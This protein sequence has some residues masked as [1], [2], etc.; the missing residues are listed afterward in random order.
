[1]A[2]KALNFADI[3][4]KKMADIERPP[5]LPVGTYSWSVIKIP[6]IVTTAD[7]AWDIVEFQVRA[8]GHEDDVDPAD[9]PGEIVGVQQRLAFMFD[10]NDEVKFMQTEFRLRM[11]LETHLKVSGPDDSMGQALNQSVNAQFLGVIGHKQDKNDAE[12]FHANI[13]RTAPLD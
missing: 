3:A 5:L 2:G 10:K 13:T 4:S 11:F 9:Y 6:S 1:M 7:E 8:V 12:L